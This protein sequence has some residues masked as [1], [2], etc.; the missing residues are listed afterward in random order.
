MS[1]SVK[2][3][4]FLGV[5]LLLACAF[6]PMRLSAQTQTTGAVSGTVTDPTGAIVPN[7][8]VTLTS[9]T[10]GTVYTAKTNASGIYEFD[11]LEPSSYTVKVSDT[12]FQTARQVVNVNLGQT[13][14]LN[15]KLAVA[16]ASQTVTVTEAPP[17]LQTQNGNTSSTLSEQQ[18]SQLPNPG[19][20]LTAPAQ[21]APGS[22]MNTQ[23]GYGNFSSNGIG[24]TE[25]YF[26]LN[27][28]ADVDP[29][30]NLGNSGAT[31]LL[32]GAN[33]IQQV[34]VVSNG[35]S[36]Q[37][38][39]MA[40]ATVNYITKSGGNQFH[41]NAVY[42][43][44]GR[45]LN[46]NS[47]LN[48]ATGT[49]RPF[50]NVNQWA[51][52]VGGPIKKNKL[53]FF[54]NTEGLRVLLPTSQLTVIPSPQFEQATLNNLAN[55][56][57]NQSVPFY[58]KIFNLYNSAPGA[59]RAVIGNGNPSTD[60][61]GC[62]GFTNASSGLGITQPCAM[63]FRST[64]GNFTHEWQL[65]TRID[66]NIGPNDR[67]WGRYQYDNGVQATFTD[68]I[69]PIFNA[70][71]TQPEHQGQI[72]ET[73]IFGPT[74][75]NQLIL[76]G[77]WYSAIFSTANLQKTLS[78]FPT[79]LQFADGTFTSLGGLDF[80]WP[81]GRNVTQA[82]IS[83]D[84]T[85]IWGNHTFKFGGSF[86]RLDVSDHDY[87]VLSSGLLIPFSASDFF[88]GGSTGDVLVQSFP[89]S[90]NQPIAYYTMG[91]YGQDTWR[92]KSNLTLTFALRA[93]H[94]S[95]PICRH[96]CF[97]RLTGP[98]NAV[99]HNANQ[100][101]NQ[102]MLTNQ[103][104]ALQGLDNI[105]WAPR[106][107]FAWQPFGAGHNWVLRGGVGLFYNLFP[108][109]VADNFSS[110][111]PL[112]NTFNVFDNNLAPTQQS[113]LFADAANSNQAFLTGFLAG[114]TVGQIQQAVPAFAPPGL[115]TS[116]ALS[117]TPQYQ[118]WNLEIQ[119]TMGQNT[120]FSINYVG[121]HG[122]YETVDNNS[123]NAFGFGSLPATAADQ[124]FGEVQAITSAG[125]SNYNGVT[126]SFTR[127]I[128]GFGAGVFQTNYTYSH[129]FDNVSN[130]GLLPFQLGEATSPQNPQDPFNLQNFYGP[131]DYDIR[132]YFNMNY[133]W[134][135]P[136]RRMLWG[137]GWAP[138]VNGWQ[139]SGT[140]F[141]RS[142]LPYS[143]IDG[144]LSSALNA[145]NYFATVLPNFTGG[146]IGSCGGA[147]AGPNATAPCLQASQFPVSG[148]ET[149][150]GL[151]GQRNYFRG[152]SYFD[153]DFSV[154]KSTAL[155][156]WEEGKLAVG[157]QFYN[158]FNHPNFDLP[159]NDISNPSFGRIENM[160]S[161]PTSIL[162]SFLGGDASPR[163]I[164]I[165][166]ELSF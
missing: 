104:Q 81:Q 61:L 23:G 13:A 115:S 21:L 94:N 142:G 155:P 96:L 137:H 26:T 131:S 45:A 90:L 108:A 71:S 139:V 35:Y 158:L 73:H 50:D 99:S 66:Y 119:H 117:H 32:L 40:G 143:V 89:Q 149:G 14:T 161:T 148:A 7:A 120:S 25:N 135:L 100:P 111:P 93:E 110:N 42:Y 8:T 136:I 67:V 114:Q 138:L 83:D 64:A 88:N 127:H 76:A 60:P 124:R 72:E 49:P 91:F 85:K 106:F 33:E 48:N 154:M 68:P 164:Q 153:T 75:S 146:A 80:I 65:S 157:L 162:G 20:D 56:G 141:A 19:N 129:A 46:A 11:L 79:T 54:F 122:I 130:G 24:G 15:F 9:N 82:Q 53:F 59:S 37:Y 5:S 118:K 27:G 2:R 47:W 84:A 151:N 159:I 109:I 51:A 152:P 16:T 30:L 132:H 29:F 107:G 87:G 103:F 134:Q 116:D 55:L 31:N 74:A 34:T 126:L 18:I 112:L 69:N 145:N 101:Y 17:L 39:T 4:L 102:A 10:K 123:V 121:N 41:G 52:S 156:G 113:N 43:W 78:T 3:W 95:N 1:Q 92:A 144:A 44:N 140:L 125:V 70:V 63:S 36:G 105:L 28:M 160:V 77:Q 62:N 133:V 147:A 6:S 38:G 150:F 12:G 58:Q 97:A 22:V 57:L 163:L 86:R 128:H 165:K 98:F 166:A